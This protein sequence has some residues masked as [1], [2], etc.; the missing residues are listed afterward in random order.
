MNWKNYSC[1]Y[2]RRY[3]MSTIDE[4][5]NIVDI[6]RAFCQKVLPLVYDESL[7]YMELVCKLSSKLNEVIENNNNLP[8]YVKDLIKEIVNSDDFRQIV[9]SVLMDTIINVK[10]PPEGITPAK[11]DGVTDDTASIQACFDY[12]NG[13]GGA[14][15][16]FPSGKYLTRTL[17]IN[18]E[19]SILGAD[20]YNTTLV[21]K[22]GGNTPLLQGVIN[23]SV[24]NISLDGNRLNQ[25]EEI[26]LIDGD[27][28]MALFD[29]VILRDSAHC[30]TADACNN[31]EFC[32]VL[33]KDI[34]DGVFIAAAGNDN[35]LTN[36]NTEYII[37]LTG[38]NNNIISPN[39]LQLEPAKI[40]PEIVQSWFDG[41]KWE[42][43]IINSKRTTANTNDSFYPAQILL[44]DHFQY[45]DDDPTPDE[46]FK[47]AMSI[48]A[49]SIVDGHTTN[50]SEATTQ[51]MTGILSVT[52]NKMGGIV[53][54]MSM[55]GR[56]YAPS[57][58]E[59]PNIVA[60]GGNKGGAIEGIS[61]NDT[62]YKYGGYIHGGE[63]DV[64][65]R[66]EGNGP[67]YQNNDT[68][69]FTR[70]SMCLILTGSGKSQPVSTGLLIQ[71]TG[72]TGMWNGIIVGATAMLINNTPGVNGTVGINF[73][74]WR[75]AKNYGHTAI[76][77]GY[78]V[79]HEWFRDVARIAAN[80]FN[81]V[82]TNK[83]NPK[84]RVLGTESQEIT[85]GS[86]DRSVED[87]ENGFTEN[88]YIRW[89]SSDGNLLIHNNGNATAL[90][91]GGVSY[92]FFADSLLPPD[93]A[94]LGNETRHFNNVYANNIRLERAAAPTLWNDLYNKFGFP[95]N[96]D[97]VDFEDVV[98]KCLLK[99]ALE[100]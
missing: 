90:R 97:I 42:K 89:Q 95:T 59:A 83:D 10:F 32:N 9:G 60:Y 88:A 35:L 27:I 68:F 12:A 61:F 21:L 73:G 64:F 24:R 37:D 4:R 56:Y 76:R 72:E 75:K 85:F 67:V 54:V 98:V 38:D 70:K 15:V 78:A 13:Q 80:S 86:V 8:Q 69:D 49:E 79:R 19:T 22:G 29:N 99:C 93:N 2:G 51:N 81:I 14:V 45:I 1:K 84:I 6:T 52:K 55:A 7:S 31:S 74:S 48:Y 82:G 43:Y 66:V 100:A 47:K 33:C 62:P 17:S 36:I 58:T 28:D 57:D 96:P 41:I 39:R 18:T 11:G 50:S 5:W 71:G 20:R 65:D 26:Y 91:I 87:I 63:I 46:N 34:G 77:Y 16:F 53:G 40:S 44:Q 23:Q 92:G 3:N 30:I 94:N 25:I